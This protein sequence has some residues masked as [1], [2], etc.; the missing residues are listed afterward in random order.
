VYDPLT[1]RIVL[2]FRLR[3]KR[4]EQDEVVWRGAQSE[5][6]EGHFVAGGAVAF[7]DAGSWWRGSAVSSAGWEGY[8]GDVFYV[9]AAAGASVG[10]ASGGGSRRRHRVFEVLVVGA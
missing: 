3:V 5:V 2:E 7:I 1:T 10:T 8:V 6:E 9:A 4:R